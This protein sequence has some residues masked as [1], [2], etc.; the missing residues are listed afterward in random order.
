MATRVVELEDGAGE[1]VVQWTGAAIRVT[2]TVESGVAL[3]VKLSAEDA[4]ELADALIAA[5]DGIP[6]SDTAAEDDN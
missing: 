2:L 3:T 5:A 4:R 1:F 6:V